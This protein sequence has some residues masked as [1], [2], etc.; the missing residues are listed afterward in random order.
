MKAAWGGH[1]ALCDWLLGPDPGPALAGRRQLWARDRAGMTAAELA[2]VNGYPAL[3]D[4]LDALRGLEG[5]ETG[6]GGGGGGGEGGDG[7]GDGEA[8]DGAGAGLGN[9]ELTVYYR[10]QARARPYIYLSIHLSIS[11]SL[12]L[13]L[14]IYIYI[15]C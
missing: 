2:R 5:D 3:A 12:S 7:G 9:R 6:G 15:Y 8:G 13:S 10:T 14:Y 11:P 4:R 1:G